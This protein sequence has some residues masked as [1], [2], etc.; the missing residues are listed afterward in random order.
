PPGPRAGYGG[1][2]GGGPGYDGFDG[3]GGPGGGFPGGGYGGGGYGGGYGGPP[4]YGGPGFDAAQSPLDA[5]VQVVI[6][7]I[8]NELGMFEASG[9]YGEQFKNA[10]RLLAAESDKLENNI[11]PEWLEVD[12]PKPIKVTKKV[13]IP[14][15]RH[16]R[17][18]FVGKILGPKGASLQAMAKQHKCHI[19]VL[20]RGSTKDR[21]KEQELLNSGDPQYA[22]Y[23]GPLHVKV[24]TIAPAHVAYQRVAGV[25]EELNRI[26]QPVR[27][28]T[29]PG[30]LKESENGNGGPTE[31][32]DGKD[33]EA[34][35]Q[36]NSFGGG[37]GGFGDRGR[38]NRGTMRGAFRGRGGPGGG[39]PRGSLD[40]V[41]ELQFVLKYR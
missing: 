4:P 32:G 6:R 13:L 11:D 33:T 37:R 21:N 20:G 22:H 34:D 7:E 10:R 26:L 2:Y 38:G 31:G 5:E 27:E 25:L 35:K 14:N 19:Y 29:T 1:G 18:N 28:D 23:G 3:Y 24:E 40:R 39:R 15:F 8:H 41:I 17:F 9:E 30:H 16:P 36:Q 12:I